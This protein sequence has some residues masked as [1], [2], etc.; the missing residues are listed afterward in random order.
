M[1][2]LTIALGLAKLTGLDAKLGRW[3]GGDNGAEVAKKSQQWQARSQVPQHLK[4]P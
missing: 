1:E 3:I 2:P 4:T